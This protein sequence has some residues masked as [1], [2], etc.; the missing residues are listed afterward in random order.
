[1]T[2]VIMNGC[3]GKM[4]QTITEI[5]KADADI[6]IVA[7][8]DLYDGI[9]NDYPVFSSIDKCDVDADVVIDFS[10]AKA[11]DGVLDYCVDK[12]VPVVLCTT[13]L[14]D[15]QLAKVEECYKKVAVLKSANMSLGINTL[16][17]LLKKA[18]QVFA[19]AGF[20]M[21]IVEKHHNLKLD[22]L[23]VLRLRLLIPSTRLWITSITMFTTAASA[24][25]SVILRKLVFLLSEE[26]ASSVSTR[27][28]SVD[29]M[30]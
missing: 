5:C 18:A 13:G 17:A 26:E 25:R 8:I 22:D 16:M 2:K 28:F 9:D 11:V 1:M 23:Q 7:G 21:E 3:N 15:E 14:S 20:D 30:R 19:P 24:E 12:Q 29:R 27:Y 6:K 10:N 4:G